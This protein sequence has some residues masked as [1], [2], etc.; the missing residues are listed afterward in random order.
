MDEMVL[1]PSRQ[2]ADRIYS[3]NVAQKA[4]TPAERAQIATCL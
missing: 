4:G 2:S 1:F 3:E